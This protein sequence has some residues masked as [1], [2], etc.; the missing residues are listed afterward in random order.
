MWAVENGR[1]ENELFKRNATRQLCDI[2]LNYRD[3]NRT[4]SLESE[5]F[6][7][8]ESQ[9]LNEAHNAA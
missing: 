8:E 9:L 7:P 1:M 4:V 6:Q 3:S 2:H 5:M